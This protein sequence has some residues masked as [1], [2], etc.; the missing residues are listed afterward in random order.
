[1]QIAF[2]GPQPGVTKTFPDGLQVRF[3]GQHP[4]CV[5]MPQIP[6]P[7]PPIDAS[8]FDRG[9]PDLLPEPVPRDVPVGVQPAPGLR[10]VLARRAPHRPI[11][12]VANTAV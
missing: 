3:P 7:N 2:G 11:A 12:G 5:R 10:M 1:M 4:R 8:R 6:D 9:I